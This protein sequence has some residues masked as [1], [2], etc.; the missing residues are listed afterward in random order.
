[1]RRRIQPYVVVL[2][3]EPSGDVADKCGSLNV[4]KLGST[5]CLV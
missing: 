3:S 4:N 5:D 2:G 1:M